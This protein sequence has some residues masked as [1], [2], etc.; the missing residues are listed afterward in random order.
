MKTELKVAIAGFATG[1]L[2]SL[3]ANS[4]QN[5]QPQ[6]Q[7]NVG[8]EDSLS[9]IVLFA[10]TEE[11]LDQLADIESANNDAA[12]GDRG[13]ARG[14]YQMTEDAWANAGRQF[15]WA[16]TASWRY[17]AHDPEISRRYCLAYCRW[18]ADTLLRLT[19]RVSE[20]SVFWAYQS[21]VYRVIQVRREGTRPPVVVASRFGAF[22]AEEYSQ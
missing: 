8:V 22:S 14:A 1:V 20:Q 6:L 5:K 15:E 2:V 9:S 7:P 21:G 10:V 19:G 17:A 13:K 11:F 3:L 12:V 18:I 16:D 4:F